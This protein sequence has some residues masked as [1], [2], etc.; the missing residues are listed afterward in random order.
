M[1]LNELMKN[2]NDFTAFVWNSAGSSVFY[3]LD[4]RNPFLLSLKLSTTLDNLVDYTFV[5]R[6]EMLIFF[7]LLDPSRI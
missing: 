5:Y 6:N 1:G 3:F 7:F 4:I 2:D